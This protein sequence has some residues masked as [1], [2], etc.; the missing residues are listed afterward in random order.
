MRCRKQA[1]PG[2]LRYFTCVSELRSPSSSNPHWKCDSFNARN[3]T[4]TRHSR[5]YSTAIFRVLAS[6]VS[7]RL[8]GI[9]VSPTIIAICS[10]YHR[11]LNNSFM[12]GSNGF[13]DTSMSAATV[14]T[15]ACTTF[16]G[17]QYNQLASKSC[18]VPAANSY[19]I[20]ASPYPQCDYITDNFTLSSNLTIGSFPLGIAQADWGE[21]G[22]HPQMA[23]GL[24]SNST[25]LNVLKTSGQIASRSWSMF[26]GR[27]G[28]TANT[29]LDG[30][31]V[32]GGYDRAKV[33]GANYTQRLSSSE[34]NCGTS[35]VVTITNIV[36]NFA[37][38]T[39]ASLF[40][41]IQ[42]SAIAACIV[43][44]YPVLM[45]MPLDPY[46][47]SFQTLTNASITDRSFGVYFYGMIYNTGPESAP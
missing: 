45:T 15:A 30:S 17:G 24:G 20:D 31:F 19:P 34:P 41:G 35:M 6:V 22:Y 36:L 10:L 11:S 21:Q 28:A 23:L 18:G 37:N 12:Y 14:S 16:R 13:C 9:R 29:Q 25:I 5:W 38:G 46:F 33:S 8:L 27:T 26:W 40:D 32:F 2:F 42:S 44:D 1:L 7:L 4:G 39:D 3:R 43:P 47:S